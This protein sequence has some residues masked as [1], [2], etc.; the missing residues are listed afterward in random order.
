LETSKYETQLKLKN[1]IEELIVVQQS[2][3]ELT[4]QIK[5]LQLLLKQKGESATLLENQLEDAN[6]KNSVLENENF[7]LKEN[8]ALAVVVQKPSNVETT[9]QTSGLDIKVYLIKES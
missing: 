3:K 1:T 5:S 8:A 4:E 6:L 7:K 2:N 9:L